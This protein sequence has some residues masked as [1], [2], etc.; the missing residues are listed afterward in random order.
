MKINDTALL[1]GSEVVEAGIQVAR[2][3]R[4]KGLGPVETVERMMSG[5]PP[6]EAESALLLLGVA[7]IRLDSQFEDLKKLHENYTWLQGEVQKRGLLSD[8]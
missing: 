2:V 8:D 6:M 7:I 4:E 1:K 3:A 5:L